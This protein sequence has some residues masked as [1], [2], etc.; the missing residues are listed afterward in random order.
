DAVAEP[1]GHDG[2][3]LATDGGA[4]P[5]HEVLPLLAAQLFSR[6]DGHL[7]GLG[8]HRLDLFDASDVDARGPQDVGHAI[9]AR[10]RRARA[11]TLVAVVELDRVLL[12]DPDR[13]GPERQLAEVEHTDGTAVDVDG[14]VA[15]A[16]TVGAAALALVGVVVAVLLVRAAEDPGRL[17]LGALAGRHL[18]A[19]RDVAAL[20]SG[21]R[22]AE[23]KRTE[24]VADPHVGASFA[25][26][27]P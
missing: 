11:R 15:E 25:A 5:D 3:R 27:V 22:D 2:D 24:D 26:A 7:G 16:A 20:A 23:K 8:A 18:R 12:G 10:E 14:G 1:V 4:E 13:L 17:E 19:P 21:E 9:A 6:R